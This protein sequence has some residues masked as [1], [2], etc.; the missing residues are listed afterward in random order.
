MDENDNDWPMGVGI[1]AFAEAW[2]S[3]KAWWESLDAPYGGKLSIEEIPPEPF[4]AFLATGP[5]SDAM[6]AAGAAKL[7]EWLAECKPEELKVSSHMIAGSIFD[8]MCE[9]AH[10]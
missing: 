9:Q 8:A 6:L 1:E 5:C 10:E 4:S 2:P 7:R 3:F